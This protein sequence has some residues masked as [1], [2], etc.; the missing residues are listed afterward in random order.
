M[1]GHNSI[2]SRSLN[3]ELVCVLVFLSF[4]MLICSWSYNVSSMKT[5]RY[6]INQLCI[7]VTKC[8]R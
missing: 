7:A 1:L 8:P 2:L 3:K 6:C 5:H 4:V